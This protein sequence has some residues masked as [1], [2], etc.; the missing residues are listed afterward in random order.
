MK[1]ITLD[2]ETRYGDDYTLSSMPTSEYIRDP[3]FLCKGFGI[4]FNDAPSVWVPLKKVAST[5]AALK[6]TLES[7]FVLHHHAYFDAA[8]LAWHYDIRPKFILDTACMARA[9]GYPKVGLAALSEFHGLGQKAILTPTSTPEELRARGTIDCELTYKLFQI[10]LKGFPLS[11]LKLID[12]TVRWFTEPTFVADQDKLK[13]LIDKLRSVRA[14][15][16]LKL[17]LSEEQLQSAD[18]FKALLEDQGVEIQ[19]KPGKKGPIPCFAKTDEFMKELIDDDNQ[20]VAAL[21]A[22]RL[23]IK[24]T[25]EVTRAERFLSMAS[26]GP[27][28]VFLSYY[29]AH[30]G[31]WSGGDGTNFQNPKRGGVIR[32]ALCAPTGCL[33]IVGDLAQ[34]EAR[35][36]AWLA[37]QEDLL[38]GFRAQRD[39]YCEYAGKFY[40]REIT[41]ADEFERFAF[42]TVILGSG[43][44]MG[45]EKCFLQMR[46][47]I[48]KRDLPFAPP[49]LK[50]CQELTDAYR[51]QMDRIV[52]LWGEIRYKLLKNPGYAIGPIISEGDK[53]RLP[54]GLHLHYRGLRKTKDGFEY[55]GRKGPVHTYGA[56]VLQN[57]IEALG[58]LVLAEQM[59][60]L[61]EAFKHEDM[62]AKIITTTHDEIVACCPESKADT[63][64]N[65]M[66]WTMENVAPAWAE[67]VPLK[68]EI[69]V[70]RNYGETK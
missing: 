23:G 13:L 28:P 70:G 38:E 22:A 40:G 61:Q 8:I 67:G 51:S 3:R 64:R 10:F 46:A 30:P 32:E 20:T 35:L 33:L 69:G 24:S 27:L 45:H 17:G 41:K 52:A 25:G 42:K 68:V 47:E 56:K 54:N 19:Y 36:T 58:R 50:M 49:T 4:K 63:V 29:G 15:M 18:Q 43:Y 5:L 57:I 2:F 34:I 7:A 59:L 9:L 55:D 11:E 44:G 66:Q 14:G 60:Y 37:K 16:V 39:V 65:L 1:I 12:M 6:P 26:H 53:L 21:A 48:R 62:R 31:R